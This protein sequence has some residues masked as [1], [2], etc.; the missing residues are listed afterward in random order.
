MWPFKR[1]AKTERPID[2]Y[3]PEEQVVLLN[4]QVYELTEKIAQ[5]QKQKELAD[6]QVTQENN[7]AT[8]SCDFE[9]MDAFS[10]ERNVSNNKYCT[11]IGYLREDGDKQTVHE[12]TLYCSMK[13]HELLVK[14]FNAVKRARAD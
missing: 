5:L 8:F 6:N 14:E 13:Q 2:L 3:T 10:I 1:N 7:E 12:W 11:I 4:K 9:M